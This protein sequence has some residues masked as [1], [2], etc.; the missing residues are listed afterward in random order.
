MIEMFNASPRKRG[1]IYGRVSTE[2]QRKN[3]SLPSQ[4]RQLTE[5]MQRDGVEQVSDPI[6]EAETS[7]RDFYA[8]DG[9]KQLWKLAQEKKID[10]VYVFDLDRLGRNAAETP[11]LMYILKS[12]YG[13][14]TRTI[15][16]EYNF[17]DP[18]D[19]VLAALRSYVGQ[20]ESKKIGER[21][22]RGKLEKFR[23]GKWVGPVPFAYMKNPDDVLEKQLELEPIVRDIFSTYVET[24]S[25]K[26]VADYVSGK[27]SAQI[28]KFAPDKVRRV[29]TN[30]AYKGCPRYADV[31][32]SSPH[33]TIVPADLYDKADALMNKNAARCKVKTCRK[34]RS[35]LD[36][37]AAEYGLDRVMNILDILKPHCPKCGDRMVGNGS[38]P[39]EGLGIRLPNFICP[40]C[41]YQRT[42]PSPSELE[43]LKGLCC[44]ACKGMEFD[45]EK[46]PHVLSKY[47]C[48]RC[49]FCFEAEGQRPEEAE[50]MSKLTLG[51]AERLTESN[52]ALVDLG[53]LRY[54]T[55]TS[56]AV[57]KKARRR[58]QG[59]QRRVTK[60]DHEEPPQ[61]SL[62]NWGAAEESPLRPT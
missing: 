61:S 29:L 26:D 15:N 5:K 7:Y 27:Y 38:K 1:V 19:Y 32:I 56:V 47:T 45:I 52:R 58:M 12:L 50:G 55:D 62:L 17:E 43:K 59:M 41:E 60:V 20:M 3:Y 34:P 57:F 33:L 44:P 35:L 40:A 6:R 48:K 22:R 28:G 36:D 11:H 49:G 30:P 10:Y 46:T 2:E 18:I 13:V 23:Q 37:L 14:V 25:I 54:A 39:V 42:I 24:G 9:L 51:T 16:E 21:T 31:D 4:I 8:R 53:L